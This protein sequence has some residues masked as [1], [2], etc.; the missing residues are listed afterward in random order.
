MARFCFDIS[1]PVYYIT[2]VYIVSFIRRFDVKWNVKYLVS[3]SVP[4]IVVLNDS[5]FKDAYPLSLLP[6]IDIHPS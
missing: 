5:D 4:S 2:I 6:D 1:I 3:C